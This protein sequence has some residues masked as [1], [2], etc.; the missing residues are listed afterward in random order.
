M[1]V[2]NSKTTNYTTGYSAMQDYMMGQLKNS[3]TGASVQPI[4]LFS[5]SWVALYHYFRQSLDRKREGQ[6][7][8]YAGDHARRRDETRH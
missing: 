4:P 2:F 7:A 8:R 3:T 1:G 5:S 6:H